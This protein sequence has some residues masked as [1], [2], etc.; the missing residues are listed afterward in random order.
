LV[1]AARIMKPRAVPTPMPAFAPVLK[2]ESWVVFEMEPVGVDLEV[3]DVVAAKVV[4]TVADM[5]E[6]TR[7]DLME[8]MAKLGTP[9]ADVSWPAREMRMPAWVEAVAA[10][11]VVATMEKR[12]FSLES[13]IGKSS[14]RIRCVWVLGRVSR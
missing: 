1:S 3:A 13:S 11:R 7:P 14:A 2:P 5:I 12:T 4:V 6:G 9:T 8:V 10:R